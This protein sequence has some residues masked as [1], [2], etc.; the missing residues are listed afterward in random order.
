MSLRFLAQ[1]NPWRATTGCLTGSGSY[2]M[3]RC[4]N[5]TWAYRLVLGVEEMQM[6]GRDIT[7]NYIAPVADMQHNKLFS[8]MAGNAFSNFAVLAALL[9]LLAADAKPRAA[10]LPQPGVGDSEGGDASE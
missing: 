5:N 8:N 10:A 2:W 7:K 1:S 9:A 6:T 4:E 3:R